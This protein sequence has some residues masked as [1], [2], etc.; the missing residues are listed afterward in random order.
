MGSSSGE[1]SPAAR[2]KAPA[3]EKQ[4]AVAGRQEVPS[5]HG[6][7]K[8]PSGRYAAEI[9][10]PYKKTPLIP[11]RLG[12]YD[13]PEEAARAYDRASW[14][15]RGKS[16]RLSF[17][18][19]VTAAAAPATEDLS[20]KLPNE[21]RGKSSRLNFPDEVTS[22]AALAT[23]RRSGKLKLPN[24]IATQWSSSDGGSG[25]ESESD[26]EALDFADEPRLPS[27]G[28]GSAEENFIDLLDGF[29]FLAPACEV[30]LSEESSL[31]STQTLGNPEG[32]AEIEKDS[33]SFWAYPPI[34]NP[35]RT[36]LRPRWPTRRRRRRTRSAVT[37]SSEQS[38]QGSYY[39]QETTA[40]E[41]LLGLSTVGSPRLNFPEEITT[42]LA[43]SSEGTLSPNWLPDWLAPLNIPVPG[44]ECLD[45][46]TELALSSCEGGGS[47]SDALQVQAA[48]TMDVP[49]QGAAS[50]IQNNATEDCPQ[51]PLQP[52]GEEEEHHQQQ[53][54]PWLV[55]PPPT[56]SHYCAALGAMGSLLRN[57][58]TELHGSGSLPKM[59]K[60][61]MQLLKDDLEEIGAYLEDLS[62]VE[63]PPLTAKCWMKEVRELTY[64]VEDYM[65]KSVLRQPVVVRATASAKIK[66]GGKPVAKARHVKI[67][68][69]PRRVNRPHRIADMLSEFR[70]FVR[71]AIERHERY[72]LGCRS[73][74]RRFVSVG[75]V[76]P[77]TYDEAADIVID[78][79][80]SKF[81]TSLANDGDQQLKVASLVG[82]ECLGKTTLARVFYEKFGAQCDCRAF[83][84]V[85]RKADMK[86][87]FRD[88]LWQVQ[89]QQPPED[90]KQHELT[91][92]IKK[93]LQDKRYLLVIDDLWDASVWDIISDACPKGNNQRSRIITTTRNEDV[94]LS[95][96]CDLSEYVFEM[97]P[98]DDYHSRKLFFGRVFGSESDCPQ[99]F[100]EVSDEIVGICG[101]LPLAIISIA[102]LLASQTVILM[103]LLM[104]IRD[105]L[106]TC[107]WANSTSEGMRQVL[108]L[109]YNNLPQYL[110][111]CLL[112]FSMYPL[113][114]TICKDDLVKQWV[115]EGFI[116]AAEGKDMEKVAASYF[117]EL[118][119]RKFLQPLCM[120]H[121]NEVLSCTVHDML[122]DLIAHKSAEENF[123]MVTDY[124]QK[125]M[126]LSDNVHRL[127]LHFGDAKYAKIPENIRT[128]QVRS[129]TFSGLSKCMPS[130]AELRLVRVLNIEL[131]GHHGDDR[132]DL[133]GI[134]ELFQLTYLK[135]AS[136]CDV[137][138][139]LP[140][141]MKGL[142][143]LETL[144]MNAKVSAVPL[145]IIHLPRLLHLHLPVET[146]VQFDWIGST[147]SV[148][149]G[150]PGKLI[151]LR[152]IR[153]TC[154]V[155]P[156]D[157]LERNMEA[158]CSLLGGHDNLKT[159]A[160]VPIATCRNDFLRA[161]SASEVTTISWDGL[162]PPLHL[163][164]FEWL[165]CSCILSR[166]PKW[167]GELGSL[168][169]LKIAIETLSMDDVANLQGL[170][171]L[172]V[173]SL[174]V[175]ERVAER[176]VFGKAGFSALKYFKFRCSVPWLK[177]EADAMPNLQILKLGFN[178]PTVD[179][180]D[181]A[182]ISIERLSGLNEI[183][184]KIGG[185]GADSESTLMD[186][187]SN[188]QSNP[189]IKVQ[190][191]DWVFYGEYGSDKGTDEC[192]G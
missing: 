83:V 122:H 188:H 98:L 15:F 90:C 159:L 126:A 84:R 131:S 109:S 92:S 41:M 161:D 29:V 147:G 184:V 63:D 64:D 145:D 61:R 130:V 117:D 32:T 18:D 95:C 162:T 37:L 54:Y 27:Q 173:V 96:C 160:M 174:Y 104:H 11:L 99:Q 157:H 137:C 66:S 139:E 182:H 143:C 172:T 42:T 76:L 9:R 177:F 5:Y 74:R 45:F 46:C 94:A 115:A 22:A 53:L 55:S 50:I 170:S 111:T 180:Q 25:S 116:N 71:E 75:P 102:S 4:V 86:R 103:D 189:K 186:T 134:S 21:R 114:R 135:V 59:V 176:I 1:D 67:T 146:S 120:N 93:H 113:G 191:V 121:N 65:N 87:V 12:T 69:L 38:A 60:E 149:P 77:M 20:G 190:L 110:K 19:E 106:T 73:L 47:R 17:P 192:H 56:S 142:Q 144:D 183:T 82:S 169:I 107:L 8:R 3:K 158:L 52:G 123:I 178:A 26:T 154:S 148:S 108:N 140:N 23:E 151:N 150:S 34:Q 132:I 152:D 7:R 105:S 156:S 16:A 125:N 68:R 58:H 155:P 2:F 6:V 72:D 24:K 80:M 81:I 57:L 28:K 118:V 133:T 165:P 97:K 43:P 187:V 124:H 39:F 10:N 13:T 78:G 136:A 141:H 44:E 119:Q 164:R 49:P 40:A 88:I 167:I 175:R 127:S 181:T 185:A 166:V 70:V 48:G 112:Y 168:C 30:S 51:L 128:S 35:E 31:V 153:L 79:R 100:K 14:E 171:A 36:V 62:E 101:G 138:I 129:V 179:R 91:D 89:R 33:S 85:S 163:Q